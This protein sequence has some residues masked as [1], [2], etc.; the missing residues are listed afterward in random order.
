MQDIT[1]QAVVVHH[2][3]QRNYIQDL[4][5]LQIIIVKILP[6]TAIASKHV[7]TANGAIPVFCHRG[8]FIELLKC[9]IQRVKHKLAAVFPPFFRQRAGEPNR[10]NF[11]LQ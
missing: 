7:N 4:F 2:R 8:R 10:Q 11:V 3:M 9:G 6:G 5:E 1:E